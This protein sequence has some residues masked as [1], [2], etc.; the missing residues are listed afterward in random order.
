MVSHNFQDRRYPILEEEPADNSYNGID[1][2][3][4]IAE[5]GKEFFARG[6]IWLLGLFLEGGGWKL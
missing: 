6:D 2:L 1:L 5:S 3:S 4:Y